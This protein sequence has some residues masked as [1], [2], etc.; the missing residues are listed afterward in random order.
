MKKLQLTT[1]QSDAINQKRYKNKLFALWYRIAFLQDTYG[2][3]SE[4]NPEL[5]KKLGISKRSIASY[6]NELEDLGL[7]KR[8]KADYWHRR[9]YAIRPN[10]KDEKIEEK[11]VLENANKAVDNSNLETENTDVCTTNCTETCTIYIN[12]SKYLNYENNL[13]DNI[14]SNESLS[15]SEA[16]TL[17][18]E[19]L[20]K[21]YPT[22][23]VAEA[24]RIY[25]FKKMEQKIY[26]VE[27]YIIGICKN[28]I[29][30]KKSRIRKI[31]KRR[32]REEFEEQQQQKFKQM[33]QDKAER[34]QDSNYVMFNEMTT[35][36]YERMNV[37]ITDD[38]YFD[39]MNE[40]EEETIEEPQTGLVDK[41]APYQT[42]IFKL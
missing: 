1:E 10:L 19:E 2:Y 14:V 33:A 30:N 31:Y 25:L 35:A 21:K 36:R 39:W 42:I 6:I 17:V 24:L 20:K 22:E 40:L 16:L 11:Q 5:A 41:F 28:L 23:I 12:N 13:S 3:C 9:L 15:E 8:V 37:Q 27:K 34:E 38:M 18:T 29:K 26:S 32:K 4:T 7:I